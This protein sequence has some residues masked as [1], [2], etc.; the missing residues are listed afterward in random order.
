MFSFRVVNR[1][2]I[3][4]LYKLGLGP[5]IAHTTA[6]WVRVPIL[7]PNLVVK[8][9]YTQPAFFGLLGKPNLRNPDLW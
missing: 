4:I 3:S 9:M 1:R 2:L 8:G 5:S 6:P 7:R